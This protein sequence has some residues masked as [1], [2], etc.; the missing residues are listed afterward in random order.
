MVLIHRRHG[1]TDGQK[2]R[3]T[4]RRH[5]ISIRRFALYWIGI[6]LNFKLCTDYTDEI[7]IIRRV[8]RFDGYDQRRRQDAAKL[9]EF[10]GRKSSS[11]VQAG[12]ENGFEKT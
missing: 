11:G 7:A 3:R 4:D 10:G 2:D 8:N 5:A 9:R 1:L 12:L 6:I